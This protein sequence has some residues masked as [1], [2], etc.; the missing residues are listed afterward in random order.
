[1]LLLSILLAFTSSAYAVWPPNGAPVSTGAGHQLLVEIISDGSGGAIIAWS[2]DRG[3]SR[4]I[5]AQRVDATGAP[6]WAVD[7]IPICTAANIQTNVLLIPDGSGGA[8]LAWL[9]FRN[10]V[11]DVY[12]Q[13]VNGSGV[14]QWTSNG[15]PVCIASGSQFV[16]HLVSDGLGGAIIVWSDH[17]GLTFDIYA[18]RLNNTGDPKWAIDGVPI[19]VAAND[20]ISSQI[21]ADGL[22]GAVVTW[23][24]NRGAAADV[25]AQRVDG[26]GVSQWTLDGVAVS[27]ALN[28]QANPIILSDALGVIIA[29]WDF[30]GASI[31]VYAQRL[32]YSGV[33]QWAVDGKA[34]CA[35]PGDQYL[36]SMIADGIVGAFLAWDDYRAGATGD[37]YAQRINNDGLPKWAL[38]GVAICSAAEDQ[39]SPE[40]VVD[41][42]NGVI[43][44][45]YD[46]RAGEFDVY[47]QRVDENGLPLWN[48]GGVALC[49][50]GGYQLE[51]VITTDGASGAIVAWYD[52]RTGNNNDVYAQ[53]VSAA[54]DPPSDV[55]GPSRGT[56][57]L[58]A[59]EVYPNPFFGTASLDIDVLTPSTLRI[60][61]FDVAG[62]VVRSMTVSDAVSSRRLTFDGRDNDGKLLSSGVYFCR[63]RAAGETITRKMV[64]AR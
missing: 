47:A 20:Q 15:V 25:Y 53:H 40:I 32:D 5:Y 64:I 46:R 36:V 4:D 52:Y 63:V 54:G 57:S 35:A 49:T 18:Q 9:D 55:S 44:T 3:T 19:C 43:L 14:T 62:R 30:R 17:R 21:A 33:A 41:D 31:D 7:G 56:P 45:W 27:T 58:L 48:A 26:A 22:G 23:S 61:I 12:A 59:G 39:S 6:L 37:I 10:A 50:A 8:I 60:D 29:W 42:A 34:V 13:R 51:P 11:Q 38:D 2:D 24:D 28:D 16:S 1:L